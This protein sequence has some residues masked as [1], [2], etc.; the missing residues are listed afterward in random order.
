MFHLGSLPLLLLLLAT[1][2]ILGQT[3]CLSG[4]NVAGPGSIDFNQACQ[5]TPLA[6]YC[7]PGNGKCSACDPEKSLE[8]SFCDCPANF[9]CVRDGASSQYGTCQYFNLANA[10]C[11]SSRQCYDRVQNWYWSCVGGACRPC[12]S[13]FYGSATSTC[14]GG[15]P[16][17]AS[18]RPGET[19]QCG[20]DGYWVGGGSIT[21][22]NSA[23]QTPRATTVAPRTSSAYS[24]A[25]SIPVILGA[26]ALLLFVL[27]HLWY[28]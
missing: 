2:S 17:P 14:Q 26:G 18:S 12:N 16:Y 9:Y 6:P 1:T 23:T 11:T 28:V 3:T 7:A 5:A 4:N 20:S 22:T 10:Q 21:A 13:T 15:S 8:A 27:P 25:L 19:R 24:T